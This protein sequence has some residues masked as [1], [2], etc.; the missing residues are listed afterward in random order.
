METQ[1]APKEEKEEDG[2]EESKLICE[3][4]VRESFRKKKAERVEA[5]EG[6]RRERRGS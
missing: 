6:D 2:G 5:A 1:L 3:T 4:E